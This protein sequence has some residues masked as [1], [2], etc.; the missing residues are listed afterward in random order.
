MK[1]IF[2][3]G[4]PGSKWSSVAKNIHTSPSIDHSDDIHGRNYIDPLNNV[5]HTGAYFDPGMEFGNWF[6]RIEEYTREQ[7]ELEFDRP[8]TGTGIRIIKSHVLAEHID[9]LK[10]TW[11]DCPVITVYRT[12]DSCMGWW[13]RAGGWSITYPNYRPYYKDDFT[14]YEHIV[15]QN[16]SITDANNKYRHIAVTN[17]Y[18]VAQIINILPPEQLQE[19]A[20]ADITVTII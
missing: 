15:Q 14:M 17:N 9:Y 4:A 5:N 18:Q 8:F 20:T 7:C 10:S 1:Y 19:Y 11:P 2:I 12:N 16:K 6:D 13:T 3:V